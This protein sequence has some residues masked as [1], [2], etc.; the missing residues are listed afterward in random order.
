MTS[1]DCNSYY[2]HGT[3]LEKGTT[4]HSL[5]DEQGSKADHSGTTI[6][7]FCRRSQR[8]DSRL[9]LVALEEWHQRANNDQCEGGK[10]HRRCLRPLLQNWLASGQLS[11]NGSHKA[12]HGQAPVDGLWTDAREG[13]YFTKTRSLGGSR[14]RRRLGRLGAGRR[15]GC[16]RSLLVLLGGA[17][18][19]AARAQG[20][21]RDRGGPARHGGPRDRAAGHSDG[22]GEHHGGRGR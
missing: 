17:H 14:W 10:D 6:K 18:R 15:L 9:V 19:D 8:A 11:A 13:H 3:S 7:E 1:P 2:N 4:V 20:G 12:K 5:Q 16:G 21:L 22:L